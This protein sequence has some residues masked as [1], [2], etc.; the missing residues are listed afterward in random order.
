MP[1]PVIKGFGVGLDLL[2]QGLDAPHAY[3]FGTQD[4]VK[5]LE[6][7]ES[8]DTDTYRVVATL[9]YPEAVYVLHSFKKKS[10]SGKAVPKRDQ[11]TIE[12]RIAEAKREHQART[13][14]K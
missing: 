13:G 12:A 7:K 9:E 6:L 2:Q 4:G 8:H 10:T 1:L 3:P 11:D 5:L 14:K